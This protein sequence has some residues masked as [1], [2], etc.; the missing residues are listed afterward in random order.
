M[1]AGPPLFML[2]HLKHPRVGEEDLD[3]GW[4]LGADEAEVAADIEVGFSPRQ[5]FQ[6]MQARRRARRLAR[7]PGGGGGGGLPHRRPPPVDEDIA[8]YDLEGD[9]DDADLEGDELD[10]EQ[11]GND[12][13]E[14]IGSDG[15]EALGGTALAVDRKIGK[16]EQKLAKL[17]A[18]LEATP[19]WKVKRRRKIQKHIA[20]VQHHLAKKKAKKQAKLAKLAAKMGVT[21]AALAAM[22]V[23]PSPDT[24]A[25]VAQADM[26]LARGEVGRAQGIM[27][28][29][30]TTPDEGTELPIPFEANSIPFAEWQLTA[31]A[32]PRTV[33][34]TMTSQPI[35][36]AGFRV[37][38]VRLELQS[39]PGISNGVSPGDTLL[40]G[41]LDSLVVNG[42]FNL[43]YRPV[44]ITSMFAMRGQPSM[45]WAV[46]NQHA[47]GL[48]DNPEL[49]VNNTATV[50]V[51][52]RNSLTIAAAI[53]GTLACTMICERTS[54]AWANR[55]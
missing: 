38:G 20:R 47:G 54:D 23:N 11:L 12:D 7:C 6:R 22:M 52:I 49:V 33:T 21:T 44:S 50:Q 4:D 25:K 45:F 55:F 36:Y 40:N 35:T 17:E 41:S 10:I 53:D 39:Q 28:F 9:D 30:S 2:R 8:G 27:G 16:L 26:S 32:G 15:E 31:G 46:T 19:T 42:G 24:A 43:V 14:E 13:E 51:T 1:S 3:I 5:A 37:K 18:K 48:R 34:V 29:R